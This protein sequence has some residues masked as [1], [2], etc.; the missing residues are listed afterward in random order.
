MANVICMV[1]CGVVSVAGYYSYSYKQY[2]HLLLDGF[3]IC[4]YMQQDITLAS[5]KHFFIKNASSVM[6]FI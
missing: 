5:V 6:V 4:F 2:S 3:S 1:T